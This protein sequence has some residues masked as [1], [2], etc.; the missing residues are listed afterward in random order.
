MRSISAK[1][2]ADVSV[3]K[4]EMEG[5][6]GSVRRFGRTV[7][8]TSKQVNA[9]LAAIDATAAKL[10]DQISSTS[11]AVDDLG[12][13]FAKTGDAT[14]LK[15]RDQQQKLLAD[16][17]KAQGLVFDARRSQDD[18]G[19]AGRAYGAALKNAVAS[20]GDIFAST[21][22]DLG[23][24]LPPQVKVALVAGALAAAPLVGAAMAG[25]VTG[26]AGGLGIG[27]GIALSLR[28]PK[29]K[30]AA[31]EVGTGIVDQLTRDAAEVGPAF[32]KS[33]QSLRSE[34]S[35][36]SDEFQRIFDHSAANMPELT[37]G[38]GDAISDVVE[39][40][41]R[42]VAESD[43]VMEALGNGIRG[44][45]AQLKGFLTTV[46][47]N[48]DTGAKALNDLFLI[49]QL[50]IQQMTILVDLFSKVYEITDAVGGFGLFGIL[51]DLYAG[52]N[53]GKKGVDD[54]DDGLNRLGNTAQQAEYKFRSLAEV[55]NSS[56]DVNL[57][58]AEA[59]LRLRQANA[60]AAKAADKKKAVSVEEEQALLSLARASNTAT[61]AADE[62]GRTSDEAAAAH[63]RQR[64][65][66]IAAA[67]AMG[68]SS[69]KAAELADQLLHIPKN[70]KPKVDLKI[71]GQAKL[72]AINEAIA[73][74]PNRKDVVVAI[75]ITG[76]TNVGS[77][78]SAVDKQSRNAFQRRGGVMTAMADGGL[79]QAGIYPASDPPLVKFAEA[80]TGG[81]LYLPRRGDRARGRQLVSEAASW[82]GMAATPMARGGITMAGGGL[83]NVA[84]GGTSTGRTGSRLDSAAAALDARNAV[85]SLN[86][87]LKENGRAFSIST[88]K[89][90]E[91]RGAL[92]QGIK[93]AQD[94]AQA[95]F[96]E[97]G[98][99]K[100]ANAVYDEYLRRL[101]KTLAQQKISS[102]V[103]KSLA[104]RPTYD[105]QAAPSN[106]SGNIGFARAQID[107]A[108]AA[109]KAKGFFD[110]S[111]GKP[112][113]GVGSS[114]GRDNLSALLDYL[115]SAE[116]SAQARFKQ[117]GSAAAGTRVYNSSIATLRKILGAAG[118]S[119][120]EI[121]SV[122]S[123]YGRITLGNRY[124]GVYQHA[125]AGVLR[126]AHIAAGGPTRYAYAEP[127]TGGELF[128]PKR[129]NLAKTR[130]EVGWAVQNW[131][132][133]QVAW[134]QP[135][136]GGRP[137]SMSGAMTIRVVVQDGAVTGLVRVEVDEQLGAL[138]DAAV[139][140]TTA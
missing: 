125:E 25:A 21:A 2:T 84:P 13:A 82:Y 134:Q 40:L 139:Y 116:A 76:N 12:V 5:G 68:Y 111:W 7:K 3:L 77:V 71:S 90:R 6:G 95:K 53:K 23:K 83:V 47:A 46:A 17:R 45:G 56:I 16:L 81:E 101:R 79:L 10:A 69:G 67:V 105:T 107:L 49:A 37:S 31:G 119:K 51:S 140:A 38:I 121:D 58:A 92:I 99:V 102:A 80:E 137:A 42:V 98:S 18:G 14:L 122:L 65:Q 135:G 8:D 88:A 123:T 91:N 97:T 120:K 36:L 60:E 133:G 127:A 74:L 136:G 4:R 39:G 128:A 117:T 43:P 41:D 73:S 78:R 106:S 9:D 94:A 96:A 61:D 108:G 30:A 34:F 59:A 75:K 48:G 72:N 27:G 66:L 63:A 32:I 131:W 118:M 110:P 57:D 132:G 20:A 50:A 109:D 22:A 52:A 33:L 11:K 104:Q 126:D 86:A 130:S 129:G 93:A 70:L 19:K 29:I 124:G 44:V 87:S 89:G 100:Q 26:A 35:G 114:F 113:F 1:V 115:S 15:Q 85:A 64:K 103:L 62:N 54:L 24:L 138:A 55:V 112:T 28:D